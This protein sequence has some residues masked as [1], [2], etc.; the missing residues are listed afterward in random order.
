MTKL[1]SQN[2]SQALEEVIAFLQQTSETI[3]GSPK[4]AKRKKSRKAQTFEDFIIDEIT[5]HFGSELA[6]EIVATLT[7]IRDTCPDFR[8]FRKMYHKVGTIEQ[9]QLLK[10]VSATYRIKYAQFLN[11][12]YLSG[13]FSTIKYATICPHCGS[14]AAN[15]IVRLKQEGLVE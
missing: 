1:A 2:I 11:E 13:I 4:P 3:S 6:Q 15:F 10:V 9:R 12:T 5:P 8:K 7:E 14:L